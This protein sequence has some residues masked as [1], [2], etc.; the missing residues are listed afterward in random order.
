MGWMSAR[1]EDIPAAG[2]PRAVRWRRGAASRRREQVGQG[3]AGRPATAAR[4]PSPPG[5]R[6]RSSPPPRARP[7]RRCLLPRD[8]P[9]ASAK[10]MLGHGGAPPLALPLARRALSEAA[11]GE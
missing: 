6:P 2:A 7:A 9:S 1:R 10:A 11:G 3:R 4:R 5:R 8:L